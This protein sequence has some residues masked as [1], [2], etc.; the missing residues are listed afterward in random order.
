[1]YIEPDSTI[2]VLKNCPLDTTYDH[3]I[4]FDDG[5][6]DGQRNY[7]EG[8][9]KYT[10]DRQS[11]QRVNRG[12]MRVQRKADDLYDCN[13]LMFQNTAFGNKWFYA[14]V[15][16]VEYVNNI[17]S[18]IT[19]EIDPMQTWFFDYTLGECF[20]EREHTVTDVVGEHTVPED[21]EIGSYI[22]TAENKELIDELD[23]VMLATQQC[24]Q[25]TQF[26]YIFNRPSIVSGYPMN[27]YWT[28]IEGLTDDSLFLV[29]KICEQYTREG[30][31]DGVV[32]IFTI[33]HTFSN[34]VQ[35][36]ERTV[37]P[38]EI[39]LS[40]D[41][42]KN[43]KLK[44][45]PYTCLAINTL[46]ESSVLKYENF[47]ASPSLGMLYGFNIDGRINVYPR[48]Y[49]GL[50]QN[51]EY[52]LTIKDFPEC[53]WVTE[54]F[55]AWYAQ[56]KARLATGT[57]GEVKRGWNTSLLYHQLGRNMLVR[58]LTAGMGVARGLDRAGD[59]VSNS[60][61]EILTHQVMPDYLHG[62][63][64]G[65]DILTISGKNGVYMKCKS[66][67]PEYVRIIDN[68]FTMFGYKINTVK[69]PNRAARP[70]WTYV[71]TI[72]C[73]LHGSV[74]SDD[75]NKIAEI[76]DSGITFWRDGNEIGNYSLDNSPV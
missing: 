63:I 56:N 60:V 48:N 14:F 58:P 8:L 33:P 3:T 41:S 71:K 22:T 45:H 38:P 17:T 39:T 34:T 4:Y 49:E 25:T 61:R 74:P 68:Y 15:K 62:S 13:Y 70:H 27:L 9:T 64:A 32:A 69:V 11:Y 26:E 29:N 73:V 7:F 5:D 2:K 18:E 43:N 55:Q 6:Y 76:Y 72:A 66:L 46:S 37:Y 10:F 67:K 59:G 24:P 20:V 42:V 35:I 57:I 31:I 75:L 1:M 36:V 53:P 19:Y 51:Y 12:T 47:D 52:C 50:S 40:V 21:L 65:A 16:S 54:G 44:T 28:V 30:P 23:I